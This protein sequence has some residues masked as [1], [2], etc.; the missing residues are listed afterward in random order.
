MKKILHIIP[1][2]GGGVGKSYLHYWIKIFVK[3]TITYI[4]RGTN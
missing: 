1:H 3:M 2:F 4:L